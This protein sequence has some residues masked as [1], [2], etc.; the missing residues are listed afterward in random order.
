MADWFDDFEQAPQAEPATREREMVPEG[1]HTFEIKA[2]IDEPTRLQIRL[3]HPEARYGWV[4]CNI[5]KDA[6][7][8]KRLA[9]ELREAMGVPKGGLMSAVAD[10]SLVGRTVVARIYHQAKPAGTYVNVGNF[11]PAA[12]APAAAPAAKRQ[13]NA[14]AATQFPDD[15]IP[16]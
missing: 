12:P 3:A 15:D 7:W 13:S 4:F 2:T 14:A 16:F 9:H 6:D 10:G 5:Y 8:A 11:K 1:E